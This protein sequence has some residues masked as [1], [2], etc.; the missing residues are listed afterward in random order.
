LKH[1]FYG[2]LK[3]YWH[4]PIQAD[5]KTQVW[6]YHMTVILFQNCPQRYGK[7]VSYIILVSRVQ[8]IVVTSAWDLRAC[9]NRD[10]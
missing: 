7:L 3:A 4:H 5:F 10:W 8:K 2:L 9:V 1:L 6:W